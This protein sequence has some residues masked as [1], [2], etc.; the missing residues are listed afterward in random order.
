MGFEN[1]VV[2]RIEE[3]SSGLA[4]VMRKHDAVFYWE[5]GGQ[6]IL[7]VPR[8]TRSG[9]PDHRASEQWTISKKVVELMSSDLDKG[10]P[11]M[12]FDAQ[13]PTK[14]HASSR[15]GWGGKR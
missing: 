3:A 10:V 2:H 15:K 8:R 6:Y 1:E 9:K 4:Y 13:R 12:R 14:A 5:S 11:P 7:D